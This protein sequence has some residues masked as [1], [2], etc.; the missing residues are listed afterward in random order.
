MREGHHSQSRRGPKPSKVKASARGYFANV[1]CRWDRMREDFFDS[2]IAGSIVNASKINSRSTVVDVGCGT[3][4]LT[5]YVAMQT[6]GRGKVVGVDLSSSMLGVA[7]AN[8]SKLGL[9]ESVEFRVGDAENLPVEDNFADA[10]VGNMVLHH[11][12]RPKRAISEMARIL[13]R[14]GRLAVSDLEKHN[15]RWLRDEMA[16]RWLG[17]DLLKVKGWLED[18]GLED[19][20]VEL[21]R[22]KCCGVSLHGR[23]AEIGIFIASGSKPKDPALPWLG[24]IR[25]VFSLAGSLLPSPSVGDSPV[26]CRIESFV[27]PSLYIAQFRSRSRDRPWPCQG[28]LLGSPLLRRWQQRPLSRPCWF[29]YRFRRREGTSTLERLWSSRALY[30]S[31]VTLE[32]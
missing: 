10:V 3:G 27:P 7:K 31:A 17:F 16:D 8:L 20:K 28:S 32:A 9:L 24:T 12:P 29:R 6:R 15:E 2:T 26:S 1:A 4:F 21:A 11:C 25:S 13:K 5:Q 18:A 14:G 30:C 23:K 22:T 19:V